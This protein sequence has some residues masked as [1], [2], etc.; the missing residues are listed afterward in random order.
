MLVIH[1]AIR[2]DLWL[3]LAVGLVLLAVGFGLLLFFFKKYNLLAALGLG[4]SLPGGWCLRE[5]VR[6]PKVEDD[7]LWQVLHRR[8]KQIV[9]VYVQEEQLMPFGMLLAE[10]GTL[11][12][13]MLDGS[14][15]S[16]AMPSRKLRL[17]VHFLRR[18]LPH[19]A[20]GFSLERR[21]QFEQDPSLLVRDELK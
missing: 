19:A 18:L 9:W 13:M 14:E 6:R 15:L 1:D 2:R 4:M 3:K 20:F 12:V 10:R 17:A 5:F 21:Q 8:Q 16:L 11:F 7:A